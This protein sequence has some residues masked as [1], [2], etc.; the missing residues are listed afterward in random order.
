MFW[1]AALFSHRGLEMVKKQCHVWSKCAQ[2]LP[3]S[4]RLTARPIFSREKRRFS[5]DHL[6]G[7]VTLCLPWFRDFLTDKLPNFSSIFF[8]FSSSIFNVL[9]KTFSKYKNLFNKYTSK[10]KRGKI[11]IKTG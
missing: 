8:S 2:T 4:T 1:Q 11:K 6:Q 10:K 9:F 3:L 7:I 5:K